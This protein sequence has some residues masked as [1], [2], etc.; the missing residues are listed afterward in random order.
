LK[1]ANRR[2]DAAVFLSPVA[3]LQAKKKPLGL[4]AVF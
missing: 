2:S 1:Q 3:M 4:R